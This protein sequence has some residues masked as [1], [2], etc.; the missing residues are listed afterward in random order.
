MKRGSC[1]PGRTHRHILLIPWV[2]PP[3]ITVLRRE[4]AHTRGLQQGY[5]AFFQEIPRVLCSQAL[6]AALAFNNVC[7]YKAFKECTRIEFTLSGMIQDHCCGLVESS[8]L[9]SQ[10][11]QVL[12]PELPDFMSSP[13]SGTGSTQPREDK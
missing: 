7:G 6:H 1:F 12:F 2:S 10:R 13:G 9:Q 4:R 8:W 11:S 5:P 3:D